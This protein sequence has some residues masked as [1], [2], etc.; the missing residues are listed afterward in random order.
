MTILKP[1][2]LYILSSVLTRLQIFCTLIAQL[3][4]LSMDISQSDKLHFD[5]KKY[6]YPLAKEQQSK[7]FDM[8]FLIVALFYLNVAKK[9]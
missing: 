6:I 3:T 2:N 1:A 7:L 8:Y 5:P 4:T 9:R